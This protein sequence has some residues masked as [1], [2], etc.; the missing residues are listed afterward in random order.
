MKS[1]S[2]QGT[3]TGINSAERKINPTS[4]TG[5]LKVIHL[6]DKIQIVI[7]GKLA[8]NNFNSIPTGKKTVLA[9]GPFGQL[10]V[11]T[12][13]VAGEAVISR[14]PTVSDD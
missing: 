1:Y 6:E 14:L 8:Y 5:A 4:D 12:E 3:I 2:I 13:V 11:A 10:N 7:N 9:W